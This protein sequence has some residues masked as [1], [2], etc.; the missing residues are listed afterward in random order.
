M[1]EWEVQ[2]VASTWGNHLLKR[3]T[4]FSYTTGLLAQ[5]NACVCMCVHMVGMVVCVV[6]T[7]NL[8]EIQV[9]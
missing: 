8:G 5:V 6:I 9:L 1:N 3:V 4:D 2:C 7:V